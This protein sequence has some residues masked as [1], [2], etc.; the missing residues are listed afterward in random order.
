MTTPFVDLR[1]DT[2][3]QPTP[4]M[5]QAI[6]TAEVGDDVY[7]E[8]RTIQRLESLAAR[9]LGKEAGLFVPS[10]TMANQIAI[11]L[12]TR[13]GDELI[14]EA[15][16]HPYNYEAGG[17]AMLSG[18]STRALSSVRGLLRP[19]EVD[20][21]FRGSDPHYAPQTLL[22]V[23][24]T[25]NRGGGTVHPLAQ[26]DALAE[27]AHAR[28]AAAHLD[29]ARMWNGVIASGDAAHRRARP[30]DTVSMCLSKGLGAPVGSVLIGPAVMMER[31]R[32]FRKAL[33]GGMRQAG[34]LAAAGLYALEH[35]IGRLEEDHRRARV[36]GEGL[37]A[38]GYTIRPVETNMV[39]VTV[40]EAQSAV[41]GLLAEGIKASSV[42]STEL[43]LVT[44]LDI[45]DD[46]VQTALAAFGKLA[47]S[48]A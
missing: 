38:L 18:V 37:A 21:V 16:G 42:S 20:A 47:P 25:S 1:S 13:A 30:F 41:D 22:V 11:H 35:H 24:D 7:G 19:S 12:H 44:H 15:G 6:A 32:R 46:H 9:L 28:G 31:A 4:G 17:A 2:V 48:A 27:V 3:T 10:G 45:D 39:Y 36:L 8:D 23:E 40:S 26:L 43:R 5:R 14:C 34:F 33:G 29:G